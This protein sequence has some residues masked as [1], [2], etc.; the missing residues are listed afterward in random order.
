[1]DIDWGKTNLRNL[2]KHDN[3]KSIDALN[4]LAGF[5]PNG[6]WLPTSVSRCVED[7]NAHNI[8]SLFAWRSM[9]E[10]GRKWDWKELDNWRSMVKQ[11]R[12]WD[13]KELDNTTPFDKPFEADFFDVIYVPAE[14]Y[15]TTL[16]ELWNASDYSRIEAL[17]D[18]SG[19]EI[20][21]QPPKLYIDYFAAKELP[22]LWLKWAIENNLYKP[23]GSNIGSQEKFPEDFPKD[24]YPEE[25][26]IAN[27]AYNHVKDKKDFKG[28]PKASIKNYL[29]KNFPQLT[30]EAKERI[31]IVVNWKKGGGP[32]KTSE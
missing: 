19:V 32:Q 10:Q 9:V 22:P 7:Q 15:H 3:W 31:S 5:D 25:L 14:N 27:K 6:P 1:M 4:I 28:T 26:V 12:E 21:Y 16:E 8:T 24:K 2:L 17:E 18:I 20:Y 11:G 29:Q 23:N 13:W 30:S